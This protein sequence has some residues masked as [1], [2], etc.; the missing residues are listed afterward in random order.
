MHR[1]AWHYR[2]RD[3]RLTESPVAAAYPELRTFPSPSDTGVVRVEAAPVT[4]HDHGL[5]AQAVRAVVTHARLQAKESLAVLTVDPELA[6]RI[7]DG[8]R[9]T[10]DPSVADFLG[11]QGGEALVVLDAAHATG[12]TA[13]RG[14][15][16]GPGS[17]DR[18]AYPRRGEAGG[19]GRRRSGSPRRADP[20]RSL[21]ERPAEGDHDLGVHTD[22]RPCPPTEEPWSARA[23]GR[24]PRD[25]RPRRARPLHPWPGRAG[26]PNR[27][28]RVCRSR[29]Q[30]D[31]RSPCAR[32]A[33]AP[34][35]A[36]A[37]HPDRRPVPRPGARG[38]PHRGGDGADGGR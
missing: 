36:P 25:G 24:R 7:R 11:G 26:H 3:Q 30:P 2:S 10:T 35:L 16:A 22:P 9:A 20:C 32:T 18:A 33:S 28:T 38:G 37:T 21:G 27:R 31:A 29:G 15:D 34:R 8:I 14:T 5:V 12:A 17:P 1:F 23:R 13:H 19:R 6:Q 4:E